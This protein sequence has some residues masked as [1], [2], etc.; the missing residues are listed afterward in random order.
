MKKASMGIIALLFAYT[1]LYAALAE[2]AANTSAANTASTSNTRARKA[3]A[4]KVPVPMGSG[5]TRGERDKRLLRE[6]KG[7]TNAG[8]CEGYAN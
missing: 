2:A 3:K 7:R 5:E 4:P 1:L 8:A 6:C